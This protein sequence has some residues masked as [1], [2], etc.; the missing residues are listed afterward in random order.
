MMLAVEIS[1]HLECSEL[2]SLEHALYLSCQDEISGSSLLVDVHHCR[3]VQMNLDKMGI[4]QV[5]PTLKGEPN[6]LKLQY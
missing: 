6:S 1:L 2:T 4:Q 3:V 5:S